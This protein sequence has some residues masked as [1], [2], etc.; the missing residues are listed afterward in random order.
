MSFLSV[1]SASSRF[2]II[3]VYTRRL[4]SDSCRASREELTTKPRTSVTSGIMITLSSSSQ[5]PDPALW[6]SLLVSV[7]PSRLLLPS[8]EVIT[9]ILPWLEVEVVLP[10]FAIGKHV[11]RCSR[12][13]QQGQCAL[14]LLWNIDTVG[15]ITGGAAPGDHPSAVDFDAAGNS[16]AA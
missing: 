4:S 14:S 1:L 6:V 9:P 16:P 12:I 10:R 15:T 11:S 7:A 8:S 3:S 2:P 5:R 13:I